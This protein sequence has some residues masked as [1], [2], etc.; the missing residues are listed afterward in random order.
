VGYGTVALT[1]VADGHTPAPVLQSVRPAS[2]FRVVDRAGDLF[3]DPRG[4]DRYDPAGASR[5][6]AT[7]KPRLEEAYG[8]LGRA[9]T[10]L[11]RTLERALVRLIETPIVHDPA[12]LRV[13]P[14]GFGYAFTDPEWETLSG[15]QTQLLRMGPRNRRTVESSLRAIA[16]AL[17]IPEQRLPAPDGQRQ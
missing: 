16:L 7:F 11:D 4:Y 2:S 5:L 3:V 14:R 8:D 13:E 12:R 10:P 15:A 6:Y 9:G 1:N 17:G